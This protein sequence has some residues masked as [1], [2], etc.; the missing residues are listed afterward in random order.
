M[1]GSLEPHPTAAALDAAA[2]AAEEKAHFNDV[3]TAFREY[4]SWFSFEISRRERH[5]ARL[6]PAYAARLPSGMADRL[7]TLRSASAVNQEFLDYLVA[8]QEDSSLAEQVDSLADSHDCSAAD[9]SHDHSHHGHHGHDSC[10]AGHEGRHHRH[11]HD[12]TSAASSAGPEDGRETHAASTA[13]GAGAT[14]SS[15]LPRSSAEHHSKVKSTLHSLAR[16]WSAEGAAER[17]A[18]FAPLLAELARTKP[19]TPANRNRQRV[20]VPGCGASRL[21]W[22]VC[23]AGYAAQGNEFSWFMLFAS[24]VIL[25]C[26]E[27]AGAFTLH[28][29]IHDAS[30]H[31]RHEDMVRPVKIPDVNPAGLLES[32]PGADFSM[33]AGDFVSIYRAPAQRWMYDAVLTCF[34]IDT[35]PVLHEYIDTLLHCLKPGGVWINNGPL[36]YHWQSAGA[37][38]D[39]GGHGGMDER[40]QRS[41][42]LPYAD[43]RYAVI[44]SGFD[45]VNE[46]MGRSSYAA[47]PRSLMKTVFSTVQFT[48]VRRA[49]GAAPTAGAVAGASVSLSS[50]DAGGT[51]GATSPSEAARPAQAG[52]VAADSE[53]EMSGLSAVAGGGGGGSKK[54][55]SKKKR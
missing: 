39:D 42:E 29:W 17:E 27:A 25:N 16:E 44:A 41:V 15:H 28:P 13:P 52:A 9:H 37:S 26:T 47:N 11:G 19:V 35:A 36:L 51:R 33:A 40:Y 4:E 12:S 49:D 18:C 31:M 14:S 22:E 54:P 7:A 20:L 30:N 46:K 2:A 8:Q 55:K 10:A 24:N 6:P 48:A 32:N 5:L 1:S 23:R 38:A 45:V 53:D 3:L 43:V 50:T 34:F 21:V